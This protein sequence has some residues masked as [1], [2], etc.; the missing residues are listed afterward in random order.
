MRKCSMSSAGDDAGRTV[1]VT[2]LASIIITS[3]NY[4]RYLGEAIESG[5]KQTYPR[6]EIIVVD[7]GSMDNSRDVIAHY[8]T[9]IRSVLKANGGQGSAFNA[10]FSASHG[11]VIFF[12]DSDDALLETAVA[13]ALPF[14]RD[15]T[16]AKVHWPLWLTDAD[17]R[18]MGE[19]IPTNLSD[20]DVL[21]AL[22]EC[23]PRSDR[24]TWPPTT[25][26]AWSRRVLQRILPLPERD[27]RTCP[28]LYLATLAPL[29]GIVRKIAEPQGIWRVHGKNSTWH[30]S[31]RDTVQYQIGL[32]NRCFDALAAHASLT[33]DDVSR[34]R[35]I[36]H[37]W[38]HRVAM[39]LEEI[40]ASVPEQQRYVLIDDGQWGDGE[41]AS[42]R[43]AIPFLERDGKYWGRPSDDETAIHELKR[44]EQAGAAFVVVAWPAFWWL[45][46]YAS[47]HGHLRSRW[48]CVLE[49]DRLKIF[50]RRIIGREPAPHPD[51][52]RR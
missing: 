7:D 17:G 16:V 32:W 10:G 1:T 48:D 51:A 49:N 35:W 28:D 18:R 26:N 19:A 23:G 46:V 27:F 30:T 40:E 15:S 45:D 6:T 14:F 44:L 39:A 21:E 24:Y 33:G 13:T 31:F 8:G 42:R 20:G 43:H 22:L 34:R 38:W 5:L 9:R 12:V 47:L 36:R 50:R 37:S 3:Y 25:G 2:P 4:G 11:D 52:A 41:I 29:F